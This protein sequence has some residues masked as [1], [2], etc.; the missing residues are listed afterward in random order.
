[1]LVLVEPL[2]YP[3]DTRVRAQV[4]ALLSA[5]HEVTVICPTG[6]G[7]DALDET[8]DGVRVLRFRMPKGGRGADGYLREYGA[9]MLRM[10]RLVRRVGRERFV[11]V[12]LVCNPPDL[13]V[14][15]AFLLRRTGTRVVLDFREISPELYEAKFGARGV[16]HR[17]LL[18]NERFA[19]RHS[20][21][22]MTVSEP[23]VTIV[24]E[25]GTIDP[26]RI[27]LV[28]NGPDVRRVYP[29]D[30]RPELRCG[31]AHLVLWL[32]SMSQQEGL[33][34]LIMA[35][36]HLVNALGRDDM[37]FAMVGPGDV[38]D[39][40]RGEIESRGLGDVIHL[41]GAVGD[42]LVRAYMSTAT[43]C[44]GVDERNAMN[45]RA[46]MRKILEYM[47]MGRAVVQFP[48]REMQRLCGD[49]TLYARNA[50]ALHLAEQIAR[51][52]DDAQL[53]GELERAARERVSQAL[54]WHH[55]VPRMLAAIDAAL[56]GAPHP[57]PA[58]H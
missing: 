55:Q 30:P 19:F 4:E 27:F 3:F 13:L 23:C 45:D 52:L 6:F 22:V 58:R 40:L 32:G 25:R 15:L 51:L 41:S 28:G 54:M 42:D 37:V 26:A 31:R 56:A 5:G 8:I 10:A 29:V 21:V 53:R 12:C 36:D 43:V 44:V 34:R 50:D 33:G 18:A 14:A 39:E 16:L 47:A 38:H 24:R 35:A 49:T 48:L 57:R 7:F 46:A 20:D 2:P 17:L 11:D 1:V 9:S